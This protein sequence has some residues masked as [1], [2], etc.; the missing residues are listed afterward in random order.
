M[1][2][3]PQDKKT[4]A[5]VTTLKLIAE[6]GFHAT[7][8]SQIAQEANISVGTIYHYFPSKEALINELYIHLKIRIKKI[9]TSTYSKDLGIKENF[10][11]ITQN[12]YN[13]YLKNPNELFFMEQYSN[14]PLITADYHEKIKHMF[15]TQEK[16]MVTAIEDNIV[17]NLHLEM[18]HALIH[19][20]MHS[21]IKYYLS[22]KDNLSE[23]T[24]S[25]G[26]EAIWDMIKK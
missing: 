20:A 10:L 26:F 16:A 3:E 15:E 24:V 19:G 8:M 6:Q 23:D 2:E 9:A 21:L 25:K 5:L 14:S 17:K 11:A 18:I 4:A 13:H 22:N 12:I 7:P 1:K